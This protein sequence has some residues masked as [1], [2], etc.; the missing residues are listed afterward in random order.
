MWK[1]KKKAIG[2]L[3]LFISINVS[4]QSIVY[5]EIPPGLDSQDQYYEIAETEYRAVL[6]A[7]DEYTYQPLPYSVKQL[8]EFK[9][10]LIDGG[11]WDESNIHTLT[12]AQALK[13]NIE[14]QFNNIRENANDQDVTL[15]YFIGHGGKNL[16]NEFIR[17]YDQPIYDVELNQ[18]LDN[19]SGKI[20]IILDSCYSGGFI[21]EIQFSERV[22]ITACDKDEV[23]Y[24]IQ[25]LESGIFGYFF[26]LCL[27]WITKNAEN[28]FHFTRILTWIYGKKATNEFDQSIS[29]NPQM[30]NGISGP[31]SLIRKH[32]YIKNVAE[33]LLPFVQLNKDTRMWKMDN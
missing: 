19:I 20:V 4:F 3:V 31:T 16:T 8:K 1:R 21:E 33:L 14:N 5:A 6:V 32:S 11:N 2:I 15:F 24:Q 27:S 30:Y 23:T 25:D 28:T 17:A 10:T 7:I 26:N 29:I 9:D 18:Y 22:I 12:N 13:I